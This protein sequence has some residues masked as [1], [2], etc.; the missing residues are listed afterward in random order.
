M[1]KQRS[2]GILLH[3]TSVPSE[4]GIGDFGPATYRF[5]DFLKRAGQTCWQILPLNHTTPSTGYSP[6]NC[7]SAF[8]GNPLLISPALMVR[9]GLLQRREIPS[10][11][12][13]PPDK[14]DFAKVTTYKYALFDVAF[15]RFQASP[16]PADFEAFCAEHQAWL[17]PFAT[18]VA[19]RRHFQKRLWCD[20]PRA[21]RDL[22]SRI[23]DC[24]L[25]K[26][27]GANPN[28]AIINPQS[29]DFERFLQYVFYRQYLELKRYCHEQG[30][31]V[32]GDVPIYVTYDSADAWSH[33]EL[34]K[35]TAA[36]RPKFIAGVPPDYFS[37]TGQLWGN[38][39]YDWD[40]LESTGFDWWIRRI[41][42]NL[43]LF[44]LVRIDHFRG[45]VAYWEVLASHKTAMHG[46]WVKAPSESFFATLFKRIPF[47]AIFAEDL[48]HITPDVREAVTKYQFPC[49]RVLQFAFSG[50]PTRNPHIP[51][52]HIRNAIV[53]TGTHDN[54]TTR[55][56]FDKEMVGDRRR[57]LFD[58]LGRKVSAPDIVWELI[59]LAQA[60]VANL[61]IIPMQDLL[62]LGADARMNYPAKAK[63]NW[64]WRMR[65]GRL[66][67]RLAKRLRHLTEI[68]GRL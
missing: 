45:L 63:G 47:A 51:H 50:D 17:E 59:R 31:Q 43:L 7:F 23:A 2:S 4:Y 57:R 16:V 61:A 62:G 29:I 39:V 15:K 5:V 12:A 26:A 53:Y 8:A 18:F 56:W 25:K 38:P 65:D 64:F 49:M 33:P 41:R 40:Y 22:G 27:L 58:Y 28:S 19:A 20:W 13:F 35:L 30:V 60:S 1:L 48:G 21:W 36:K 66:T 14:V 68:H 11:P 42:H 34:F 9:D 46:K 54:N 52:N 10:P 24:G 3:V 67:A 6:Y 37:K 32:V 55:G 44:D